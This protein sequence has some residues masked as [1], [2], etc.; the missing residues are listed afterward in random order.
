MKSAARAALDLMFPPQSLD[1]GPRPLA[2]GLTA[3]GWSQISF[4]DDPVCDGCG[5]SLAMI[6]PA[7]HTE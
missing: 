1:D 5:Q 4:L 3:E 7:S 6:T 2:T